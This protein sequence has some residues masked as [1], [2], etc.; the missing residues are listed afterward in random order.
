M[1]VAITMTTDNHR[2]DIHGEVDKGVM[3]NDRYVLIVLISNTNFQK[4]KNK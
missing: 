3:P 2:H 1:I 4:R